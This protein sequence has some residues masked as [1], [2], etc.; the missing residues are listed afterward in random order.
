MALFRNVLKNTIAQGAGKL[1]SLLLS[2]ITTALLARSLG[3]AGYGAYT[4][5]TALVLFF[6]TISDWGTNIIAVREAA[7]EKEKQPKIFGSIVVFRLFLAIISLIFLNLLIRVRPDWQHLIVSTTIASFILVALSFK[8]SFNVVFQTLLRF[9]KS[10]VVEGLSSL[11]FLV[12]VF[13]GLQSGIGLPI[14]MLGWVLATLA[15]SLLGFYLA[16][17]I[18]EIKWTLDKEII[19]N[20]FWEALPAGALFLVFNLYNRIDIV[21]LEYFQGSADVGVYGLAYKIHEN[22]VLGAAFLMNSMFPIL[23]GTFAKEGLREKLKDYYQKTFDLLLMAAIGAGVL[24]FLLAPF[25][26]EVLGGDKFVSSVLPLRILAFAT[27]IA[28]FNHLTGYSLIAFGRQRVALLI[29]VLALTLNVAANL[30]FIPKYSYLASAF[31]TIATEGLVLLLSTLV[32]WKAGGI[33]PSLLSFPKTFFLLLKTKGN[34][35]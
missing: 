35:F 16:K 15:A 32:I 33:L 3:V 7:K 25:I 22:L 24:T 14:V 29:A 8:T 21:I 5:I 12:F 10:A 18:S 6:A 28:Y 19:K 23:A 4:F 27:V 26:I 1:F 31:I 11:L 17:N 34:I 30:L 2:L 9:E 13:V 20:L